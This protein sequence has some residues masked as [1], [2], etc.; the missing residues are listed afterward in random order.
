[1]VSTVHFSFFLFVFFFFFWT[2]QTRG[3]AFS[4]SSPCT[5]NDQGT[6]SVHF[7]CWAPGLI[8]GQGTKI[9]QDLQCSQKNKH[10]FHNIYT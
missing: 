10:T 1:M 8:P 3:K 7:H 6:G 2:L 9:L 4:D 5:I